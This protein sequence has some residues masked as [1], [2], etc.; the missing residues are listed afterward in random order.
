MFNPT[1]SLARHD[2]QAPTPQYLEDLATAYWFSEILFTAVELDLFSALEPDGANCKKLSAALAIKPAALGRFL[3]A[4]GTLGLVGKHGARYFNTQISRDCLVRGCAQDQRDSILWRKQL[5][6]SWRDLTCCLQQGGRCTY[7]QDDAPD[8]RATRIRTYLRAMDCIAATKAPEILRA[9]QGVPLRGQLLDVGAGS[10]ALSVA[11]LKQFPS[12]TATLFDLPDVLVQTQ[13]MLEKKGVRAKVRY[14]AGNILESWPVPKKGF[15]VIILSNILHAYSEQELPHI[16]RM[17][18]AA[19]KPKGVLVIH[20][21]FPEHY[22]IKAA[23]SDLNMFINTYN[24]RVLPAG[25]VRAELQRLGVAETVLMPL[26]S[27]TAVLFASRNPATIGA[28]AIDTT[29]RVVAEL[30]ALGFTGVHRLSARDIRVADWPGLKCQFG[31]EKYASPHCPPHSP[32]P[33]MTRRI[34]KDY[35][36]ALLLEGE[37]P[38]R[39]FQT[40]VLQAERAAFVAGFHKALAFWAGPCSLCEKCVTD[41]PCRNPTQARPAME[42]AGID[43]F[44][45][46][47]RAGV[48]LRTLATRSDHAKYFGL[49]LLE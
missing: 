15:D 41:G 38:T 47:R 29:S 27:D 13:A 1:Q 3:D 34:I 23:L 40:Q 9:F 39:E 24:G 21:F 17:A 46:V 48:P 6:S 42:A 44:A 5:S 49:L 12:L 4:L 30:R 36:H 14:C 16:L 25:H 18:I 11:F 10:G 45:T 26:Q 43:V 32:T 2:P 19:L 22:P 28:L 31:C 7:P 8:T 33:A 20:D 37:P 35:R